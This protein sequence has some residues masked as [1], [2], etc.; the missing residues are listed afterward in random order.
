[1]FPYVLNVELTLI[2]IAVC[3]RVIK[4]FHSIAVLYLNYF[5][6]EFGVCTA[7]FDIE[8]WDRATWWNSQIS[9]LHLYIISVTSEL[10]TYIESNWEKKFK[11]SEILY[12]IILVFS[13][14]L[15]GFSQKSYELFQLVSTQSEFSPCET[16]LLTWPK[17]L[18]WNIFFKGWRVDFDKKFTMKVYLGRLSR[19]TLSLQKFLSCHL[20][21]WPIKSKIHNENGISN[22]N[23][24]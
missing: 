13:R 22:G 19:S 17:Q 20:V 8:V 7:Y 15:F 10:M 2:I 16:I 23:C 6:S 12:I 4:I 9:R 11:I 24:C 21:P 14:H 5:S 1:M 18:L 3:S